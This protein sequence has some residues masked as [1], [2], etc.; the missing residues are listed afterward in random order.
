MLVCVCIYKN[1]MF[2]GKC[3]QYRK[4][5]IKFIAISHHENSQYFHL[6]S[7][8][9]ALNFQFWKIYPST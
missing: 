7:E 1:S 6:I 5:K 9:W 4:R 8:Y 3:G 2:S